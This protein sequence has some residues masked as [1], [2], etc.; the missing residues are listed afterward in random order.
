VGFVVWSGRAVL[1]HLLCTYGTLCLCLLLLPIFS[2]Y[3][4]SLGR[5]LLL[6]AALLLLPIFSA[7][8]TSLGRS[9]LLSAALLLLPIFS[10]YGTKIKAEVFTLRFDWVF[11]FKKF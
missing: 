7:Y 8:G 9:L 4:T 3:G 6:S 5:S 2:A 10:A 11:G 1:Y